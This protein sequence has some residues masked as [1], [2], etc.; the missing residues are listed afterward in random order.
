MPLV[1]SLSC[2]FHEAQVEI[3]KS[4]NVSETMCKCRPRYLENTKEL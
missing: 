1:I 2:Y 3:G 4:V